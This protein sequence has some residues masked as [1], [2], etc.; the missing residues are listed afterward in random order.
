MV[1]SRHQAT[2][3]QLRDFVGKLGGL[4]AEHRAVQLRKSGRAI[5]RS[6]EHDS[7]RHRI[8]GNTLAYDTIGD[9][10]QV[11]GYTTKSAE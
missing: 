4:Q 3:S 1:Q 11:P 8:A 2:V 7:H 5:R 6:A 9:F 10:Q